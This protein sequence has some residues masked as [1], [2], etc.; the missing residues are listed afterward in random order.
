V[1]FNNDARGDAPHDA[2]RLREFV[3]GELGLDETRVEGGQ[4]DKGGR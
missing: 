2:V 3:N 1:Y 4:E